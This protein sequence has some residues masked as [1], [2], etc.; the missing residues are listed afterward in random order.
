MSDP[1]IC[2][3]GMDREEE[4]ALKVLFATANAAVGEPFAL[5]PE[6]EAEVVV[7]DMDTIYGHMSWLRAH[8]RGQTVVALS[9]RMHAETDH[10]LLRPVDAGSMTALLQSLLDASAP[11]VAPEP[12]ADAAAAPVA[13]AATPEPGADTNAPQSA[14][15]PAAVEEESAESATHAPDT[16][17]AANAANATEDVPA[18]E[19]DEPLPPDAPD[20]RL[21]D[22]LFPGAL[23]QPSRLALAGQPAIAVDPTTQRWYGPATLKPLIPL[24]RAPLSDADW[25]PVSSADLSESGEAQPLSRL[26][27][28]GALAAGE[29]APIGGYA[30]S[31]RFR[32]AKWPQTER[33]FP[34][35]F[36][37]ATAMMKGPA[38]IAEIAQA[39]G[40]SE[41]DVADFVNANLATGFAE[42]ESAPAGSAG[43][44]GRL[45]FLAPRGR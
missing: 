24:A 19:R 36:R 31:D 26:V 38:T 35:H 9:E 20:R 28:L 43:A 37:I 16:P 15:E 33:E 40:A 14:A 22:Y 10:N 2:F 11:Q 21:L 39:S 23:S 7:V 4:A 30:A 41:S 18:T 25:S 1:T 45:G 8:G 42:P 3:T 29:G 17:D 12:P 13:D 6:T 34:R 5:A 44:G 27:W 32:L